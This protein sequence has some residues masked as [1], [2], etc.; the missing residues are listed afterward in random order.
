MSIAN[1][2][3]SAIT[4]QSVRLTQA[5]F[6]LPAV[7]VRDAGLLTPVVWVTAT[8]EMAVAPLSF[9]TT[10]PEY[11]LVQAIFSSAISVEKVALIRRNTAVSFSADL[12][13][14]TATEG[15]VYSFELDGQSFSYTAGSGDAVADIAEGLLAAPNAPDD[16]TD[17]TITDNADGSI[18]ITNAT[19]GA[20]PTFKS[21]TQPTWLTWKDNSAENVVGA[22]S[23]GLTADLTLANDYDPSWYALVLPTKSEVEFETASAW[24]E[25]SS[26]GERLLFGGTNDS[27]IKTAAYDASSPSTGDYASVGKAATLGRSVLFWGD[28]DEQEAHGRFAGR[29]LPTTVGSHAWQYKALIGATPADLTTSEREKLANKNVN[30]YASAKGANICQGAKVLGG[31][32]IDVVRGIDFINARICENHLALQISVLKIPYNNA[33]I[34]MV[35]GN[36]EATLQAAAAQGI[37]DAETIVITYKTVEE[38]SALDRARRALPDVN[39][40]AKVTGAVSETIISGTLSP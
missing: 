32:W 26:N 27:V 18:T 34:I 25:D 12:T 5:G 17:L 21:T 8:S 19:A 6:G 33:G 39:W 35:V 31:E 9:A 7:P 22:S 29:F 36:L 1:I 4:N 30:Y 24:I 13:V 2:V 16:L 20:Y 11:R 10:S 15:R 23:A 38:I 37:I 40:S 14:A 28:D 3:T